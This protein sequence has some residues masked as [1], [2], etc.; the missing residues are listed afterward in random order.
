MTKMINDTIGIDISKAHL[1]AHR[2]STAT[3]ARFDNTA[4]G[5]RAFERWLGQTT[6]E[7]VVFE[8]T[9]PYHRRLESHFS[10]RLPLVK[11]NPL[12]ARRFA[13]AHGT[14]AKTDA[15]DARML[16]LM[17]RALELVP[18]QPTDPKQ[19][20]IKELHVAR[21]GLVR[22]RTAL[23]NRLGTQQLDVTRRLTR[24]RL[25][26]VNHQIDRLNAEIERRNRD[27]PER[28]R[29]IGILTSIPGIGA[30]TARALLSECPEIGTLGSKQIAAL[31]G[32]APIT[33]QSG[34]WSGKAHIQG[35][36]RLLRESLFMP[37]LVAMKRNPDL[38]QKYDALRAAGKPH[39][40]ALAVLMRKLL[41]LANTL[42]SENREWTPKHP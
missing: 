21:T 25:R 9:G 4:T 5:L 40:V 13:Q 3:H 42:I 22:D 32:L 33:C 6:P 1:D 26:Q 18:D 37:A 23:M 10:G 14:R 36:R 35:G 2:L 41:I 31:A 15:V 30:I 7:R 34:Q 16:A 8:P 19:R 17:G 29:A 24:A 27:C 11:V 20:E 39:K 28:A 38:S 12:Q